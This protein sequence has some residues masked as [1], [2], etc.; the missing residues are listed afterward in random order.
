MNRLQC[1]Y[2]FFPLPPSPRSMPAKSNR[3][4][5]GQYSIKTL[6]KE[7]MVL[8]G[9]FFVKQELD[10]LLWSHVPI[11]L[12]FCCDLRGCAAATAWSCTM[13]AHPGSWLDPWHCLQVPW[14]NLH[15]SWYYFSSISWQQH[16][17]CFLTS[18]FLFNSIS[19]SQNVCTQQWD[20]SW[21][22]QRVKDCPA[23]QNKSKHPEVR[24]QRICASVTDRAVKT[25]YYDC[26]RVMLVC[27]RWGADQEES[28][29]ASF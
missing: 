26:K 19:H 7:H 4:R 17:L 15:S 2:F 6:P 22:S 29:V 5:S 24:S 3:L 14:P 9:L 20:K 18:L 11:R 1:C 13:A 28:W 23:T 10:T 8:K 16:P 21:F 25:Q 12:T 27:P